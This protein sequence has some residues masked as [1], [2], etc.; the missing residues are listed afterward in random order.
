MNILGKFFKNTS[1]TKEKHELVNW[2][3]LT[4]VT[5]LA[6]IKK[7]S[8]NNLIGIFKHST[9]CGIS[10]TVLRTFKENLH[11]N[12]PIKMY[13]LDLLAYRELSSEIEDVFQVTHQSPQLLLIK[14][15]EVVISA[16]HYDIISKI[17][18]S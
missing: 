14:D 7:E 2:E 18:W 15:A 17:D 8:E 13:Y 16:S 9:R 5:Q 11:E 10:R 6:V 1:N 3:E 12:L 4:L